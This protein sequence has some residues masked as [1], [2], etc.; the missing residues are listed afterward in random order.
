MANGI[1]TLSVDDG[2]QLDFKIAEMLR[3]RGKRATFYWSLKNPKH[4]VMTQK[5]ML[6]FVKK[7]P[8]MEIGAHTMSHTP[9]TQL[10]SEDAYREIMQSKAW[11]ESMTGHECKSFCYP[12]GYYWQEHAT[13]LAA[14]G[15]KIARAVHTQNRLPKK[16]RRYE[17]H[18]GS[19][20]Y[21]RRYRFSSNRFWCHAW[22]VDKYGLW[23]VLEKIISK[24]NLTTNIGFY[25]ATHS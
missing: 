20:I 16:F 2:S 11:V 19:Q 18:G 23:W 6:M 21:P 13:M 24:Y 1:K 10:P 4:E 7:Y 22:E 8:E 15:F 5:Q 25:E 12:K 14:A 9:L 17:L 3:E